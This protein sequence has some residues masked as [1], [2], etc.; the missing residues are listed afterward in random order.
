MGIAETRAL[1][2]MGHL[3]PKEKAIV[4]EIKVKPAKIPEAPKKRSDG[5]KKV[6]DELKKLYAMFLKNRRVCQIQAPGCTGKATAI[7]HRKGRGPNE[8]KDQGTWMASCD[9]CNGY[10]EQHDAWARKNGFK[11]SRHTK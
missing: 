7:R 4:R 5:M 8:I 10:V 11:I 2:G 9:W 1:K 6:M 3:Y